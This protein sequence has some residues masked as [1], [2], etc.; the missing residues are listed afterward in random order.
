MRRNLDPAK[1]G[2]SREG[3]TALRYPRGI[4]YQQV[5]GPG[6]W[7]R[8]V[9]LPEPR[10]GATLRERE[11]SR[12]SRL[13]AIFLLAFVLI[14]AGGFFQFGVIDNDHPLMIALLVV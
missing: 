3:F 4:G 14:E 1:T 5:S 10:F 13:I 7:Y 9:A 2:D 8:L 12:H 6:W 11:R